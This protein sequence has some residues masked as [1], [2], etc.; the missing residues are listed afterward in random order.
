MSRVEKID[1]NLNH[2]SCLTHNREILYGIH[3]SICDFMREDKDLINNNANERSI[4]HKLAEYLQNYFRDL[5]VDCE[6]NR[7][8]DVV[9]TLKY[10]KNSDKPKDSDPRVF[11]DI[12]IHSR[13]TDRCNL[14]VI[15]IKKS[16]SNQSQDIDEQKLLSFTGSEYNYQLGVFLIADMNGNRI[17]IERVFQLGKEITDQMSTILRAFEYAED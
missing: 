7:H 8:G 14:V 3:K 1:V 13:G 17:I 10:L 16:N 5:K 11:P 2:P 4:S 6:Y 15:E 9:K 12:V